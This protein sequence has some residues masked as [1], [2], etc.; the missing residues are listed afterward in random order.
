[1]AERIESL[2]SLNDEQTRV[3]R[4]CANRVVVCAGAGSGKTRLL[5][6]R[7]LAEL[8]S[9]D[10]NIDM[11]AAITFTENAAA[12]LRARIAHEM[13][14]YI[15]QFGEK[16]NL[17]K[18]ARG[19]IARAQISTIHGLASGIFRENLFDTDFTSGFEISKKVDSDEALKKAVL[20]TILNLR[21]T[22]GEKSE[23]LN[24]LLENEQFNLDVI[25][26]NLRLTVLS[27]MEKHL[28]HPFKTPIES[29]PENDP[30]A[31][32]REAFNCPEGMTFASSHARKRFENA[33]ALVDD[34]SGNDRNDCLIAGEVIEHMEKILEMKTVKKHEKENSERIKNAAAAVAD[35][36]N[37][38]LTG[39]YLSVA[40]EVMK[41]HE[42][43]KTENSA[44][45]Y[46]DLLTNT[47]KILQ[48]N[49]AEALRRTQKFG[50][51][52]VDEFQDTDSAQYK[53]IKLLCG[54]KTKL[55]VVGD[56]L[57][58]IY[59]FRGA[60]P[61][62]F[63]KILSS[64]DFE[65]FSLLKNYRTAPELVEFTNGLF[66]NIF[67]GYEKTEAASELN[68]GMF[69][70]FDVESG[71]ARQTEAASIA[72]KI[73][74]LTSKDGYAFS[75]I[76]LIF[77]RKTNMEIYERALSG[78]EVPF[79]RTDTSQFFARPEIRDMV[80]MMRFMANPLDK[81]AEAA[82][83]R[84]PFFGISDEG[85]ARYFS[86][87][88][89]TEADCGESLRILSNGKGEH[90]EA[91][92]HLLS[93]IENMGETDISSPLEAAQFAAYELGLA[94]CALALP[95]GRQ[96]RANI[97]KFTEICAGLTE[98]GTGLNE[99]IERFDSEKD[100]P[101]K[102][103]EANTERENCVTL[104]TSH[105]AKGLEFRVVFLADTNYRR[106]PSGRIAASSEHGIMV[107]YENCR[108][109]EWERIK[110][111][112]V[113]EEEK[114]ILYVTMT[115]AADIAFAQ[116]HKKPSEGSLARIIENGLAM[117]PEFKG[118]HGT[119]PAHKMET[120]NENVDEKKRARGAKATAQTLRP[121]Y[122]KDSTRK[123]PP[124]RFCELART[125]EGEI[126]HRFFQVWDF[127]PDSVEETANF[128]M[129][130]F[131]SKRKSLKE[132]I[133][134]CARNA[135]RSPL[136][137]M[138]RGAVE[139]R[140]EYIFS[141]ENNAGGKTVNGRIDLLIETTDGKTVLV[142]YK[143]TDSFEEEKYREQME[144]YCEAIEKIRGKKPD[145]RYICVLPSA[146]LKTV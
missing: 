91:A 136:G 53:I 55:I 121:L 100:F 102:S 34:V 89:K 144:S 126:L 113:D 64:G 41:L 20:K 79:K 138:A 111:A 2:L 123:E 11:V 47:L 22:K 118:G 122:K 125:E 30:R 28:P 124:N 23:A 120:A 105:S 44:L 78:A 112:G 56:R 6:A 42:K 17:T 133:A 76:A 16:G 15:K 9:G 129:D 88:S 57:Q 98:D 38:R 116:R 49:P 80:S 92:R 46:N 18:D 132:N 141:V 96:I 130:E 68:G 99:A 104:M 71:N 85:L 32:L 25:T 5:V 128:V 137:E 65:K 143:Y 48:T 10:S 33:K 107:C 140:R 36:L 101:D 83:L 145:E 12:E 52:M 24:K 61:E 135:L 93:V 50:L 95:H 59:G 115:R 82:V 3:L 119:K 127:L 84:S 81:I 27:A 8:E 58:S 43:I 131:F 110:N 35:F 106:P 72:E 63:D 54:E 103:G 39:F 139:L 77:R 74:E 4:S 134:L 21:T 29:A 142:D 26:E 94:A 45:E 109:G 60:E 86:E 66:S 1:M 13:D 37:N 7:F 108:V 97:I 51:I 73:R 69:E 40:E 146:E 87:K 67:D 75:D 70:M 117:I 114:R 62:L 19:N 31:A 90:C 14:N